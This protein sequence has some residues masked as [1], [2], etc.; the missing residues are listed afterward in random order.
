[1]AVALGHVQLT[2]CKVNQTGRKTGRVII[3]DKKFIA[4]TDNGTSERGGAEVRSMCVL[5]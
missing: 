5:R 2:I 4:L 3:E 1:M